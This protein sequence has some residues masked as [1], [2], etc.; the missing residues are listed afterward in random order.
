MVLSAPLYI[1]VGREIS[2]TDI[3]FRQ[4]ETAERSRRNMEWKDRAQ[5]ILEKIRRY[6]NDEDGWKI[7]KKSVHHSLN[8]LSVGSK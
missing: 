2:F 8:R 5:L 3:V 1:E 6:R 7:S 4:V